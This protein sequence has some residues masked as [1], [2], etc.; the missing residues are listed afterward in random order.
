[1]TDKYT[2]APA[3]SPDGKQIACFYWDEQPKSQLKIAV[4]PFEG[5]EFTKIFEPTFTRFSYP[6][7]LRNTIRWTPDGQSLTY[8]QT[9]NGVDN[10]W[11]LSVADGESK[12]LTDFKSDRIFTFDWSHDG[13]SRACARGTMTADV[14]LISDFK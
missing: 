2:L 3:I 1:M 9:L 14:V 4:L 7:L 10:I 12:Q 5:G 13:Q 11:S 6:F 8:L